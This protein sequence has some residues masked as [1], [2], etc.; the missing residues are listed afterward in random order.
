IPP[1][2]AAIATHPRMIGEAFLDAMVRL[3]GVDVSAPGVRELG[4][5]EGYV[6]RQ[7]RGWTE[8]WERAKTEEV[9]EMDGVVKWLSA[10]MP[11]PLGPSLIQNDYQPEHFML[12]ADSADP[13]EAVLDWEVATLGYPVA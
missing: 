10:R 1:A 9:G 4:K 12:A 3:H 13:V 8:R 5:P 6:E 7:V 11:P 2:V